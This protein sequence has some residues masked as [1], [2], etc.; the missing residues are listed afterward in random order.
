[1]KRLIV[2][3]NCVDWCEKSL[4]KLKTFDGV[5]FTN[6]YLPVNGNILNK[7]AKLHFCYTTN[8]YFNLPFK[9]IWYKSFIKKLKIKGDY[10]NDICVLIYDHNILG[11]E[12]KFIKYV[13][14]RYPNVKFAYIFT[15]IVKYT[16][17]REQNYINQLNDWYDVVFAFDPLDAKKYNFEYSTLIYDPDGQYADTPNNKD[18]LVFYVGQAKDRFDE[19][20]SVYEK[21]ENLNIDC[22]FH[23]V[24][25]SQNQIKYENDIEYNRYMTY[26][27]AL[28]RIKKATCLIDIVQGDSAGL[29]IKNCE[30]VCYNK[31]LI[32]TNKSIE[33]YPFY[34][35]KYIRIIESPDD[36]DAEFFNNN[37]NVNYTD[38][39][40]NY[41][42]A[43]LFWKRL[44][45]ALG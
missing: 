39:G 3:G 27:E 28:D 36:I 20:I 44:W 17:A 25:V 26:N 37:K 8:K 42:S 15:N 12:Y 11:K 33:K 21:L 32:T 45:K 2:L 4:Y 18:D 29:T 6:K 1:M 9:W 40:D 5:Y 34:D 7:I 43:D 24:N 19:L 23:I 13:K 41:F 31:K 22:D 16:A 10:N 30:A 14:K 35:P 38:K